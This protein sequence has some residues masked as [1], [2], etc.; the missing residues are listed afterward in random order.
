MNFLHL[1]GEWKDNC[2]NEEYYQIIQSSPY[3]QFIEMKAG[4]SWKNKDQ[5]LPFKQ[6]LFV[7]HNWWGF[8]YNPEDKMYYKWKRIKTSIIISSF[9][10]MS[11]ID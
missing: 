4:T 7:R 5:A 11:V 10:H 3:I 1:L 9:H 8:F 2:D 6:F